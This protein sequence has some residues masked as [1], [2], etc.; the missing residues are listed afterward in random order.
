MIAAL[1]PPS[2][3]RPSERRYSSLVGSTPTVLTGWR[4]TTRH[5]PGGNVVLRSV[6]WG[7]DGRCLAA[8]DRGL[9]FWN[10]T[11]WQSAP[12]QGLPPPD[13]IGFVHRISAGLFLIGGAGGFLAVYGQDG[14]QEVL[15]RPDEGVTFNA[16]SGDL[17]DLGVLVGVRDAGPPLLFSVCGRRWLR[18]ASLSKAASVSC[19][20]RLDDE[21][22]LI[23][24]RTP[25]D[26]GFVVRYQPL[27]WDVS[28]Q[29]APAARAY[30]ASAAQ[31][32]SATA[33]VA[34]SG[35]CTV[36][37]EGD[38]MI[39]GVVPGEPD[40]SAVGLDGYGR[41]WVASRG[42]LWLQSRDRPAD[43]TPIWF[44]PDWSV[45]IV[46]LFAT[47]GAVIAMS[48]DGGMLEGR[49]EPQ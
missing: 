23:A 9:W 22:W 18:P 16:A 12:D 10:G 17:A 7:G 32:E 20:A 8:T 47:P 1:R 49:L 44:D 24:G 11:S 15:S 29:D 40:L 21:T 26:T 41:C 6:A 14:V 37:F 5:H 35:G 3:M 48:A 42:K 28:R 39:P 46:S 33:V 36:R 13:R 31:T 19:L 2:R 45:P 30:I 27:M 25:Q 38:R 43:W 4:W 34:G